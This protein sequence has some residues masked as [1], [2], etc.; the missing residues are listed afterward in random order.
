MGN[1]NKPVVPAKKGGAYSQNAESE[2]EDSTVSQSAKDSVPGCLMVLIVLA[3][4]LF[5]GAL[6]SPVDTQ[7]PKAEPDAE[8]HV[9][10][11]DSDNADPVLPFVPDLFN[12]NGHQQVK[13]ASRVASQPPH[14]KDAKNFGD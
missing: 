8:G 9:L 3:S 7:E 6:F 2:A 1:Q 5:G 12:S 10:D 14:R 13:P 4:L 11:S